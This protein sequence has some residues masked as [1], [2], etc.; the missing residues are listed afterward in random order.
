MISGERSYCQYCRR[1]SAI[2]ICNDCKTILDNYNPYKAWD[3]P[4]LIRITELMFDKDLYKLSN[5]LIQ[6][7]YGLG[8]SIE[9]IMSKISYDLSTVS[10]NQLLQKLITLRFCVRHPHTDRYSFKQF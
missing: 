1:A 5:I 7:E 2:E 6:Y 3:Y 4:K 9:Q 10:V 8:V